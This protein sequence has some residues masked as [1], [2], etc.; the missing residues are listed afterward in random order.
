MSRPHLA[1]VFPGFGVGGAQV[2]FASLANRFGPACRHTVLALNGE[3]ACRAKLSPDLDIEFPR[4]AHPAGQ[5]VHAV[6]HAASCLRRL[7]PDLVVTSNWGAIEWAAG[8][9]LAGLRHLHTE[10]GFGPEE[11]DA[12][13]RRRVLTRRLVLHG[14]NV[15]LP[16]HRLVGIATRVWKLP[17]VRLHYIANGIDLGRFSGAA[18]ACVPP[19][20][21]PVIGTVAALRPEKN[22]ARLLRAFALV[23]RTRPARLVI[24]G[25]GPEQAGLQALA[26]QLGIAAD[27][28]FAG[29]SDASERWYAVMDAFAL[30]SDTEQMPLS[31][32]EAMASGLPAVST[33]VGDVRQMLA[34]ENAPFVVGLADEALADGLARLL[35]AD[36]RAIGT[37][38]R[39]RAV[40]AYDQEAMFAAYARLLGI[41]MGA[42]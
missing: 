36:R 13:I 17:P 7:A 40:A 19:G 32:L 24:V 31:L 16:S 11:R 34:P 8:A 41:E 25:D 6:R 42:V 26:T 27:T 4:A 29:Y 23:R 39:A 38:N 10:D 14:S 12:Q 21:G 18:P 5:M 9:R 33:D 3:L 22:L 1:W 28:M 15:V 2:R 20:E 30:S 37:A 35:D